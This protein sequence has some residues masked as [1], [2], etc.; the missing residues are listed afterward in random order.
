VGRVA[1]DAGAI[2]LGDEAFDVVFSCSVFEHLSEPSAVLHEIARVTRPGG[3][4]FISVHQWAA[5]NGGHLWLQEEAFPQQPAQVP[6]WDHLRAG[7]YR[8]PVFLNRLRRDDYLGLV[9]D[10]PGL[11]LR[12]WRWDDPH[13][14]EHLT[15]SI[16]TELS[17]Y[18]VDELAHA[19]LTIVV[20]R[21]ADEDVR[22][23]RVGG[24]VPTRYPSAPV[25]SG[26]FDARTSSRGR[27]DD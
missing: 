25:G 14:A 27:P 10:T 7:M 24:H 21:V 18:S 13:G 4:A 12:E 22:A 20:E 2:A 26:P 6:P 11:H 3:I 5:L 23:S 15:P 1:S 16:A 19:T 17:D 9:R 8:S